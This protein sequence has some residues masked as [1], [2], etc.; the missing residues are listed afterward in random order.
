MWV[1]VEDLPR[2]VGEKVELRGWLAN[3]R[4][5]GKLVFL[6]LRDGTGFVQGVVNRA[7]VDEE[8]FERARRLY[9]ES[10]VRVTGKVR[11]DSR[12]PGGVELD[13]EKI[14]VIQATTDYP[15]PK[16]REEN[17][18]DVG[19]LLAQRHLWI[20]SRRQWAILR[21]RDEVQRAIED[22]LHQEGF[23]RLDAP[24][25]TTM[26]VE[27]TTTLFR[28]DYF[29]EPAYLSQ[30][31]QLYMEALACSHGKVYC[32]G[33]TFRAEKSKTR[34]HLTEF[35]MM[36]P[37]WAF[38]TL[39]DLLDLIE[40]LLV[41]VVAR[42]LERRRRELEMLGRDL[43]RLEAVQKPFPR[44]TYDEAVEILH[45]AGLAFTPPDDFGGDE[46]TVISQAFDRPVMVTHYPAEVKAFYM[47]RDPERPDRVRCVDVLAPE[48]YG[49]IVGG[50]EREDDYET[51]VQRIRE[52]GLPLEPYQ[53]YLDL[54]RYGTVPHGGFGLGLERTVAWITGVRHVRETIPFPRMLE[55]IYP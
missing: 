33:P 39:E 36:E 32:F 43:T 41:Y 54:R 5:S 21:V 20:R 14:E 40:N 17:I 38:A 9:Y 19:K 44:I 7:E 49:E 26:A 30:S 16:V 27:G 23:L 10:S 51:L 53:W 50:S 55:K 37:E 3:R 11:A 22:F 48:G 13:V 8:T 52:H 1:Y 18:P 47:K 29:G 25:L 6:I 45:K 35:W 34:R 31:G 28:T 4:K 2:H 12:A 15:I 46:E 24:I 42:V